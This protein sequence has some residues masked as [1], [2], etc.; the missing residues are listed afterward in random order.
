[1]IGNLPGEYG[2]DSPWINDYEVYVQK[3]I[4]EWGDKSELL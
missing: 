3:A 2:F 4:S 1:M